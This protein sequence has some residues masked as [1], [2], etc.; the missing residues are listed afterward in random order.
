MAVGLGRVRQAKGARKVPTA[1]RACDQPWPRS[2]GDQRKYNVSKEG[3]EVGGLRSD[4]EWN[5]KPFQGFKQEKGSNLY[6]RK[7]LQMQ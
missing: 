4:P 3:S 2:L 1:R 5:R 7:S 6:S